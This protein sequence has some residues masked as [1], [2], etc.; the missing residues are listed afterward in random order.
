MNDETNELDAVFGHGSSGIDAAVRAQSSNALF[1]RSQHQLSRYNHNSRGRILNAKEAL[2]IFG[3]SLLRE[4]ADKSAVTTIRDGNSVYESINAQI[5]SLGLDLPQ[6]AKQIKLS[7]DSQSRFL[8][9]QQVP[10]KDLARLVQKINLN[11][12]LLGI[13]ANSASDS[14]LANR[15]RTLKTVE[16]QIFT[17]SLVLAFAEAAWV[18]NQQYDLKNIVEESSFRFTD[19]FTTSDD[20]GNK[21]MPDYQKGYQLAN[22]TR[23]LLD[24][25]SHEPI[26][27]I[28]EL[29]ENRLNIPVIQMEFN[30]HIGGATIAS[31]RNRGIVVNTKGDN[32]DPFIRRMTLAH[33]LGHLLWDPDPK[34][35]QVV[36]DRYD[37]IKS[38]T[39]AT[40]LDHVERRANA[41][42]IELLAPGDAVIREFEKNGSGPEAVEKVMA[43]YGVGKTAL[44]YHLRNRSHNR[45]D[46]IG[47]SI[48]HVSTEDWEGRESLATPLFPA[49][50]PLSRRGKISYYIMMAHQH[51]HISDDTAAI[52]FGCEI[53]DLMK[54]IKCAQNY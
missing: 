21:L 32:Q 6:V 44:T 20:Y 12:N 35:N 46:M 25:G 4:L 41:F 17:P 19:K 27:S 31:G 37:H 22:E 36:V 1:V 34:L 42:A 49:S 15:L 53:E 3:W 5:K 13:A 30:S 16:P 29:I 9:K 24:I 18:I 48:N 52:L 40:S 14:R 8:N 47:T 51:R 45:I 39:M 33:E 26:H 54:S 43:S 38:D 50:V 11:E 28:T 2:R 10:F 7:K 23:R